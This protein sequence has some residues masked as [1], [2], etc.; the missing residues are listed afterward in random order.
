MVE[1]YRNRFIDSY[2]RCVE[3]FRILASQSP[4][5]MGS[6]WEHFNY[7]TDAYTRKIK[8]RIAV[9]GEYNSGKSTIISAMTHRNDIP[10]SSDLTTHSVKEYQ[11]GNHTLVDTPPLFSGMEELD[12]RTYFELYRADIIVFCSTVHLLSKETAKYF[13]TLFFEESFASKSVL[14]INKLSLEA[15]PNRKKI[16]KY[17]ESL[18]KSIAPFNCDAFPLHFIDAL[19]YLNGL[20]TK[21]LPLI[22]LS[23]FESFINAL[24]AFIEDKKNYIN[25]DTPTRILQLYLHEALHA[26]SRYPNSDLVFL[27]LQQRLLA[28]VCQE[29]KRLKKEL[30][31]LVETL[32]SNIRVKGFE[33]SCSVN[34]E[35]TFTQKLPTI[36]KSLQSLIHTKNQQLVHAINNALDNLANGAQL[37][38]NGQLA[39]AYIDKISH[40]LTS[41]SNDKI[42]SQDMHKLQND[43]ENYY[44]LTSIVN[45]EEHLL[46][47]RDEF[48]QKDFSAL[49]KNST[50]KTV[51]EEFNTAAT[52]IETIF[53]EEIEKSLS[54]YF[55]PY[56]KKINHISDIRKVKISLSKQQIK[57]ITSLQTALKNL[58][59]SVTK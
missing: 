9:V 39:T 31:K 30:I 42:S 43:Y 33:L 17:I 10:I 2:E 44:T 20:H 53:F 51:E 34:S 11:W 32:V 45:T 57:E 50:C 35:Q 37:L 54:D 8:L 3:K 18:N 59:S 16:K 38:F 5:I 29:R 46:I 1:F 55:I 25:L 28:L 4:D 22:D 15:G 14:V 23:Q 26:A 12:K 24:N 7:E 13:K 48:S 41:D 58:L 36:I 21:D 52:K 56:E 6:A 47:P 49:L 19:D 27:E 40:A